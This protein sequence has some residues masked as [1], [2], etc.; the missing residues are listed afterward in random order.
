MTTRE[1]SGSGSGSGS[2]G[3]GFESVTN[4]SP[5]FRLSIWA[6][7]LLYILPLILFNYLVFGLRIKGRKNLRR[8]SK[9]GSILVS[10]HSLYLDPAI[11]I[12]TLLPRRAYYTALKSHFH[13][14]LGG[15]ILRVMGG[16]PVPGKWGMRRAESTI[17]QAL[18]SGI[19]VHLFP[20]GEMT[21]LNQQPKA[22][23]MGA[24]YLA[25]RL[26]ASIVPITIAY[27]PRRLF[28]KVI[29]HRFIRVT[30][31]VGKPVIARQEPGESVR[32]AAMRL[33]METRKEMLEALS[34]GNQTP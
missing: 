19:D 2:S 31:V 30:S 12:H 17:R 25:V 3:E 32:E 11:L 26:Q 22:F 20:E 9:R 23:L 4:F 5:L 34:C 8:T 6:F 7:L 14:P 16:I 21:H 29:N 18:D 15:A 24:F 33:S 10:N 1:G 13:N 28:G 27:R